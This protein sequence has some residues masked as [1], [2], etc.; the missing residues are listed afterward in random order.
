MY[1]EIEIEE[2]FGFITLEVNVLKSNIYIYIC[3]YKSKIMKGL[4]KLVET[5]MIEQIVKTPNKINTIK[6]TFAIKKM[7]TMQAKLDLTDFIL[8]IKVGKRKTKE[9]MEIK[10]NCSSTHLKKTAKSWES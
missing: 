6:I 10:R 1:Y 7:F 9:K 2:R 4:A 8:Y 3:M 5:S